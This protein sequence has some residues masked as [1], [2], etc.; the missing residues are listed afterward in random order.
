MIR[1]VPAPTFKAKV[2]FTVPG[3]DA[4][5]LIEIEFAHRA[6]TALK[7]W[8]ESSSA[9]PVA[10]A[11]AEI[12]LGWSGV[13]DETG[14]EVPYSAD[15]LAQFVGNSATRGEELLRAYL[16]ELTESRTKN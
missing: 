11:M 14:A 1:L 15:A 13:V 9:Q 2:P 7:A 12:V 4:P 16:R 5:A 10:K 6:P 3:A 8:W